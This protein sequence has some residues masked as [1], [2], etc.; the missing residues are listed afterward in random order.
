MAIEFSLAGAGAT[1]QNGINKQGRNF[2]DYV[3]N[4]YRH[5]VGLI[6]FGF[7]DRTDVRRCF[8]F[9]P[10]SCT[11]RIRYSSS[12]RPNRRLEISKNT[13]LFGNIDRVKF[14]FNGVFLSSIPAFISAIEKC[15][16]LK[17]QVHH[18]SVLP[19]SI[20]DHRRSSITHSSFSA[21]LTRLGA[22]SV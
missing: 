10:G 21:P 13:D 2:L 18:R 12:Y 16:Q 15:A 22:C 9:T 7:G 4:N 8:A 1:Y 3:G 5:F 11:R 20:E 17:N 14:Y 19:V 6:P